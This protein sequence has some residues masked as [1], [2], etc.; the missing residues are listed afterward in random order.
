[1]TLHPDAARL[2]RHVVAWPG[3]YTITEHAELVG[4]DPATASKRHLY[5]LR[6]AGLVEPPAWRVSPF[7][8]PSAV[9][10]DDVEAR[11]LA[12]LEHAPATLAQLPWLARGT[13]IC[14]IP[15][16]TVARALAHLAS[17]GE[18]IP[19]ESPWP[20]AAGRNLVLSTAEGIAAV[21]EAAH[22]LAIWRAELACGR[23]A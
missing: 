16:R 1:V 6:V 9:E 3:D 4:L 18:V 12:V 13:D 10:R 22:Q 23:S 14:D 11:L 20:T 8:R 5:Q 19:A 17:L 21:V 2:L 15:R 7:R